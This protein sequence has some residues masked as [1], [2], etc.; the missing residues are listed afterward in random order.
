MRIVDKNTLQPFDWFIITGSIAFYIF[1]YIMVRCGIGLTF[2]GDG[3]SPGA[4][5]SLLG[6]VAGVAGLVCN[7]LVAKR[8]ILN[9]LFGVV[10]VT[11]YAWISWQNR[12][13]GDVALNA[14]YYLPMQFIGFFS[15]IR[16]PDGVEGLSEKGSAGD[17]STVR[18]RRLTNVQ[19]AVL[20]A[21]S[22]AA[23]ALTGWILEH[24]T[25]DPQP[26]KDSATTVLSVIAMALMVMAYMEQWWLWIFINI[27]GLVM[28]VTVSMKGGES[29][30]E[31]VIMWLF[32]LINSING[33]IVW[34]KAS[35]KTAEL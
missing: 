32:Y 12:I 11:L 20:L 16:R 7:V 14:L 23:V 21:G 6:A 9:Y 13:Y 26:Y 27:L 25:E 19:R 10:N 28:W 18:C 3:E 33:Y 1:Y 8:N 22:A 5:F 24:Y 15:W 29:S 31:M 17:I 4:G 35:K 30:I 2:G 34:S